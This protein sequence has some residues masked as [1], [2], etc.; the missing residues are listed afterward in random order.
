MEIK[1]FFNVMLKLFGIYYIIQ[2]IMT[3]PQFIA[4]ITMFSIG[5]PNFLPMLGTLFVSTAF[6]IFIG[7]FLILKTGKITGWVIADQEETV[8]IH[9][10]TIMSIALIVLGGFMIVNEVPDLI[11]KLT[12]KYTKPEANLEDVSLFAAILKIGI[13]YLLVAY[14]NKIVRWIE[15]RSN[16]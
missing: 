2:G 1:T 9:L 6:Y 10:S 14:N 8:D 3:L 12:N 16:K 15:N 13:G 4:L 5:A 7:V 11:I